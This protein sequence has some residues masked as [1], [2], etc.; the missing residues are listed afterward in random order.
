[1][2]D[3]LQLVVELRQTKVYRTLL[4]MVCGCNLRPYQDPHV[5]QTFLSVIGKH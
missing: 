5:A 4:L 3:K 2:F 1:M